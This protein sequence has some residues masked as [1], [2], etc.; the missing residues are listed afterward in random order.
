MKTPG[1]AHASDVSPTTEQSRLLPDQAPP[2]D[3]DASEAYFHAA[4]DE[5][6]KSI[7]S[8]RGSA[9]VSSLGLLIFLQCVFYLN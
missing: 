3:A 7:T 5:I 1:M 2:P 9:I 4:S 6:Q 8:L